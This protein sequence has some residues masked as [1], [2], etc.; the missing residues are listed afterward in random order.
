M[1]KIW[2]KGKIIPQ[3]ISRKYFIGIKIET[4]L[5]CQQDAKK[6]A[7]HTGFGVLIALALLLYDIPVS[8]ADFQAIA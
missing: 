3:Y 4:K 6:F 1:R 5:Y 8:A 2:Y 7:G